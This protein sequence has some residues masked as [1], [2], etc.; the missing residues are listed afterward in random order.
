MSTV[1]DSGSVTTDGTDLYVLWHEV[2]EDPTL[3]IATSDVA[4]LALDVRGL[5]ED[6]VSLLSLVY[7]ANGQSDAT[8]DDLRNRWARN[9]DPDATSGQGRLFKANGMAD[10]AEAR[11]LSGWDALSELP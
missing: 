8:V 4:L 3:I 6:A 2:L 1:A 5:S 10:V 7:I 9:L 11:R